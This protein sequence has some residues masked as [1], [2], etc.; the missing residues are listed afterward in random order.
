[1]KFYCAKCE[2]IIKPSEASIF[3]RFEHYHLLCLKSYAKK[4]RLSRG[5]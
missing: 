2:K 5:L 1:M 3:H 4:L